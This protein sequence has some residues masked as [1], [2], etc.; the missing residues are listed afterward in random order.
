[1][2]F[3][4]SDGKLI[5][6]K[7][8]GIYC[9]FY[10]NIE[11]KLYLLNGGSVRILKNQDINY[12][13]NTMDILTFA[14]SKAMKNYNDALK[15]I[16]KGI[17]S[18]GGDGRIHGCIVDIDFFNHIYLNPY[19]GK[20][21]YYYATSMVDKYVYNS[22]KNLLSHHNEKLL[23]NY[24]NSENKENSLSIVLSKNQIQNV[25]ITE[26]VPDTLMYSP[27]RQMLT[28]QYL[29]ELNVIRFWNDEMIEKIKKKLESSQIGYIE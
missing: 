10:Q 20:I 7:K 22:L 9:F 23:E 15:E 26:Y 6:L 11:G 18:I 21:S 2:D 1:M 25:S 12:Y 3:N 19:D 27:S 4:K 13:Y 17:K 8:N 14:I 28:I 5:M 29:T 16:S 24:K